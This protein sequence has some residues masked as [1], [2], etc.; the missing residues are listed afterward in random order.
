MIK[1]GY[2]FLPNQFFELCQKRGVRR[3]SMLLYIY[4]RGLF[5]RFQRP[6]FRWSDKQTCQHLGISSSTLMRTRQ[7]LKDHGLIDYVSGRG[8]K[9]TEYR[10]FDSGLLP[11]VKMKTGY[12]HT[13]VSR[14]R[15]NDDTPTSIK[16]ILK[17]QVSKE[18]FQGINEK[19]KARLKEIGLL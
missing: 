8:S 9:T 3:V 18:F 11:V 14:Y 13:H 7:D 5:A 15:Q 4:L 1:G 2:Q 19:E 16:Q 6:V 12:Q 17:N 10:M